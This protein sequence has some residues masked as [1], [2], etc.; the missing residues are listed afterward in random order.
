MKAYLIHMHLL[1]PRSRSSAKFKVKCKGYISQ[2]MAFSGAFMFHK[3]ILFSTD[4]TIEWRYG[5]G[6]GG[7]RQDGTRARV[8]QITTEGA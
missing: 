3:H 8:H 7:S 6:E 1:V 5:K 2:K 4:Y